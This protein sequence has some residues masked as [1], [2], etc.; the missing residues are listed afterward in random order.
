[1]DADLAEWV[2]GLEPQLATKLA[3]VGLMPEL[4]TKPMATLGESL[5]AWHAS[6][7]GDYK[8][9]SLPNWRQVINALKEF[10]G[11]DNPLREVTP[12]K[13]EDFRQSMLAANLRP[14]T[15][16]KRLQ[17]ARMF[18]EHARRQGMVDSNPF[19]FVRHRPGD[20]SERRAYVPVAD[21]ER[22]IEHAPNGALKLLVALSRYAGLRVPSEALS[23]RWQDVDWE[24]RRLTVPS[25]KTEHIAGRAYRVIPQFPEIRPYLEAAW[26][27]A[28]DGAEY[29]FPE[30]YRRRAQGPDGWANVN[31][32]TALLRVLRNA[33]LE[34]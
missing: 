22:A 11:A 18:F 20:A 23:L 32:R 28:P 10:L 5:E 24:R 34:P 17:H 1:M 30:E 19:E 6:R 29:I 2:A 13:A 27:Q 26:D 12:A 15:I 3:R 9:A 25:P 8:P 7:E 31:L 16:H 21:V 33:G 14:T 4:D